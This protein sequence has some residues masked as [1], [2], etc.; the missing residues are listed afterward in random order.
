MNTSKVIIGL[1]YHINEL[2]DELSSSKELWRNQLKYTPTN[3][4]WVKFHRD[5]TLQLYKRIRFL[6]E[7][8]NTILKPY[9]NQQLY[10][11][12]ETLKE[13]LIYRGVSK[14][15]GCV[16]VSPIDEPHVNLSIHQRRLRILG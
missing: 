8:L 14:Y 7:K 15:E 6:K 12:G 2:E 5:T 13:V 3:F 16:V 4:E 1:V 9:E 10:V 11:Y